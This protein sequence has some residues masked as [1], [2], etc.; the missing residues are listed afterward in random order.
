M[1]M[2][3]IKPKRNENKKLRFKFNAYFCSFQL[4]A[5]L[6]Q[7]ERKKKLKM[8]AK[9]LQ[10]AN[11]GEEGD[12][13]NP[14]EE[15]K[16]IDKKEGLPNLH[17]KQLIKERK[18]KY[19]DMVEK[20]QGIIID[21]SFQD[22]MSKKELNSLCNQLGYCQATNKSYPL[23]SKLMISSFRDQIKEKITKLGGL[24]W[25]IGLLEKHY[26]DYF[27]TDDLIYLTGDAEEEIEELDPK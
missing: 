15:K 20:G 12:P 25:G 16:Q 17:F 3:G 1:K 19:K 23:P 18:Q 24:H 2:Y 27:P 14:E 22:I 6:R 9:A 10:L 21:C 4:N 8:E 5:Q 11:K 26:T 13:S 7:K